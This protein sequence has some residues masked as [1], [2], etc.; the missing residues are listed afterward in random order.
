M[1][2]PSQYVSK[3][4]FSAGYRPRGCQKVQEMHTPS[5]PKI[6]GWKKKWFCRE[7]S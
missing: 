4:C 2:L 3:L 1:G 6:D 5:E 7:K